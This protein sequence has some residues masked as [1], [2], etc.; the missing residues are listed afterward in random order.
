MAKDSHSSIESSRFECLRCCKTFL[1][2]IGYVK[3]MQKHESKKT[4]P[5]AIS[6]ISYKDETKPD[7]NTMVAKSMVKNNLSKK[8]NSCGVCARSFISLSNHIRHGRIHTGEK[9]YECKRFKQTF[10]RKYHEKHY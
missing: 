2:R 10:A 1:Y 9:P 3:H 7:K 5:E 4:E 8:P 6:P